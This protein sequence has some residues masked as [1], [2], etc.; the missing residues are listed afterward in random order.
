MELGTANISE[1]LVLVWRRGLHKFV[2]SQPAAVVE[3]LDHSSGALSRSAQL[4]PELSHLCTLFSA[5]GGGASSLKHSEL[6]LQ[7][8]SGGVVS[9]VPLELSQYA[10]GAGA[11]VVGSDVSRPL[12]LALPGELGTLRLTLTAR[13][14]AAEDAA[15]SDAGSQPADSHTR[16]APAPGQASAGVRGGVD[17]GGSSGEHAGKGG[18]G[19]GGTAAAVEERWQVME[20]QLVQSPAHHPA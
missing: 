15:A 4:V 19:G 2:S 1:E 11:A 14:V 9:C 7:E 17:G 16:A 6:E 13:R 10:Q 5:R 20:E 3:T 8:A 18:E 12:V